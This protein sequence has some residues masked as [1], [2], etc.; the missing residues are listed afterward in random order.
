MQFLIFY[1]IQ[2]MFLLLSIITLFF[3]QLFRF[4]PPESWT[5]YPR[6]ISKVLFVKKKQ[7]NDL[8]L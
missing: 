4:P 2:S 5:L 8:Q 3:I 6:V 7:D 1:D